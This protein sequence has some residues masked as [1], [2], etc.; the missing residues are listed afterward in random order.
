MPSKFHCSVCASVTTSIKRIYYYYYYVCAIGSAQRRR[1]KKSINVKK[2]KEIIFYK[3]KH[4]KNRY[5]IAM[6]DNIERIDSI[7]LLGVIFN[8][9]LSWSPYINHILSQIS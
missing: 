8:E 6:M 2:T 1:I 5:N 7:T 4:V 3:N 9:N